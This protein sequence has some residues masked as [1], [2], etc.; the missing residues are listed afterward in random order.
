MITQFMKQILLI[1]YL[2]AVL[3]PLVLNLLKKMLFIQH[4]D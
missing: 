3:I 2:F 4:V 1:Y